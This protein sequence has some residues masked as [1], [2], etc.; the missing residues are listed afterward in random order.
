ML[1][2]P[3]WQEDLAKLTRGALFR[4]HRG[5]WD[6]TVANAW[7][8]LAVEKFANRFE[9]TPLEGETNA[10]L[11]SQKQSLK[12]S[13][14]PKGKVLELAWPAASAELSMRHAGKG[15]PWA[16]VLSR[17]AIPLKEPLSSGYRFAKAWVPV[18]QKRSG[19][20]SKG[21]VVR[22]RLEM[23]AQTDMTWVVASDPIPAGASI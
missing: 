18:E 4:Q 20:W 16:T 17:A 2:E 13:A 6:T 22:V 11:E 9:K 21:D 5:H 15:K 19:L 10:T 14:E 1:D 12:W 7:G 8:R 3:L 23:E